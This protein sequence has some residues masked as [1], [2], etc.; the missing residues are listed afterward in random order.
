MRRRIDWPHAARAFLKRFPW[1]GAI[2]LAVIEFQLRVAL[3]PFRRVQRQAP[4]RQ[5]AE[6]TGDVDAFNRAAESYFATFRDPEY[7]IDKPYSEGNAF[8]GHLINAGVLIGAL[9]IQPGAR[10]LEFGA[11]SCWLSHMLNRYGCHTVA[12]DVSATALSL[13]HQAFVSD[14]RVRWDLAP[15]FVPYD[16]Y[17]L[18]L[19]DGSV[20]YVVVHD[21]F[22]HVPNQRQILSELARVLTPEGIVGMS[23]PGLGHGSTEQ[24]LAEAGTTGVLENEL[25]LADIGELAHQSGFSRTAIIV[26]DARLLHEVEIERVP[27]FMGG[28]GVAPYWK[29]LCGALDRHHYIVLYKSSHGHTTRRPGVLSALITWPEDD[30]HA[31]A[32]RV[33]TVRL[34]VT[35]TGD[36]LWLASEGLGWTRLGILLERDSMELID[37]DW[38]RQA[39]PHDVGPGASVE[40][41]VDVVAPTV[42]GVYR[43]TAD[44]VIEGV[45]WFAQRGSHAAPRRKLIVV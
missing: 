10:V 19:A 18:P 42:P 12:V 14:A 25:Y 34:S 28:V 41:D 43:L 8:S 1:L 2:G 30:L 37:R 4:K 29:R 16:G 40:L 5:Q 6:S 9:H 31:G 27:K 24:S 38:H 21:A 13:G 44:M 15:Q 32:N 17:T 35:N 7:L 33:F 26:A 11:G 22:H 45:G 39:L 20:D 23:E 3:L 36:T